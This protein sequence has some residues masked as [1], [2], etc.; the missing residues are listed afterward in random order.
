MVIRRVLA[1]MLGA[2]LCTMTMAACGT[3]EAASPGPD[4]G[5]VAGDGTLTVLPPEQRV[6]APDLVGQTLDGDTFRLSDHAGDVVVLNVWASWCAPCRAEAP[7]LA[8]AATEFADSGV[9]FV[10]LDT[11]DSDTSAR[12]FADRFA[13][14]YPN[15]IDGDGRLQLLFADSLP[16]QA[17]PSTV[18][19]DRQGRVAARALGKVS[20]S[21]LRGMLEPLIA[22]K[23]AA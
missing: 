14:D 13:V 12:S 17:I 20:D 23:G 10:G 19:I 5:F 6:A 11:R 9:Q 18:V 15:V 7:V 16:P 22:E 4:S 2:V 3:S 1:A 8:K 21:T